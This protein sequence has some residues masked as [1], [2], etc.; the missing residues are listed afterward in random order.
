MLCNATYLRQNVC[1]T[2]DVLNIVNLAVKS[3]C[4]QFVVLK[5]P[6]TTTCMSMNNNH[7]T[8]IK[9]FDILNVETDRCEQAFGVFY[10]VHDIV[11]ITI[12]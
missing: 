4:S 9:I 10:N 2:P 3:F 12:Q 7:A 6:P 1:L 5:V 8:A 11:T